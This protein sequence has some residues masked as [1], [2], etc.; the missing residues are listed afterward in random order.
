MRGGFLLFLLCSLP[1]I[2]YCSAVASERNKP[3]LSL[4]ETFKLYVRT[5][6]NS[7]LAGM[8]TTVTESDDFFFLTV[9]GRLLNRKEYYDFH[10][11]WF[12]ETD[13][14]MPVDLLQIQEGTEYGYTNA[15]FYY[16][17]KM[18]DDKTYHLESYF[19]LIFRKEEGMW[20]VVA[21]VCTPIQR[22]LSGKDDQVSYDM[23]QEYL[24]NLIKTQ[25]TARQFKPGPI[26]PEHLSIILDAG[27]SVP[28]RDGI[29]PWKL[30][31]IKD[32][33]RLNSLGRLL[34]S[35]WE[36]RMSTDEKLEHERRN[37]NIKNGKQAIDDAMTASVCILT[38]VD[39][40]IC[41][42]HAVCCDCMAVGNMMLAARSLGYGTGF[43][44]SYFPEEVV[45]SFVKAPDNL[46]FIYAMPIGVPQEWIDKP[47]EKKLEDVIVYENFQDG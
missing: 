46:S 35:A 20:K 15:V 9:D 8:F 47:D 21:D 43:H 41:P 28:T 26:P 39:T 36:A 13:W 40:T 32:R 24:F 25:K 19:T 5:V 14:E 16:R 42:E 4:K 18:P 29:Q 10:K 7:D 17:Q 11:K 1:L 30:V 12:G 27:R 37:S 34:K 44:T 3:G 31:V 2:L 45:K 22:Y 23:H 33:S 6:Q 38:F